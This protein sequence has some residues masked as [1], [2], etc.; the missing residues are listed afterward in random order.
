MLK[1]Y[2]DRAN[3]K[4]FV[5]KMPHVAKELDVPLTLLA[6][7]EKDKYRKPSPSMHVP[8]TPRPLV[9]MN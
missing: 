3:L 2:F 7:F 5:E 8:S 1:S 9:M 4:A 6:A